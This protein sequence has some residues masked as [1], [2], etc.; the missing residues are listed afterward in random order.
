MVEEGA[1]EKRYGLRLAG[2]QILLLLAPNKKGDALLG[3]SRCKG[4]RYH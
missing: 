2:V 1:L 3:F 4:D